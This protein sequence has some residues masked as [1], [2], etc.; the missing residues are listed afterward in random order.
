MSFFL[1]GASKVSVAY[2]DGFQCETLR[3]PISVSGQ[4]KHS[5]ALMRLSMQLSKPNSEGRERTLVEVR[6][7]V[8]LEFDR[9][10]TSRIGEDTK[11]VTGV[12]YSSAIH[13]RV[14]N[15]G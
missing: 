1:I 8:L 3:A 11:I 13:I 4:S 5:M 12:A 14:W 10:G 15:D 9:R 6:V 2:G 7:E